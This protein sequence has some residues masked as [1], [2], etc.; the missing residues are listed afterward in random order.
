MFVRPCG[1]TRSR[2]YRCV[3]RDEDQ[4]STVIA[5]LRSPT[6]P[7]YAHPDGI[8]RHAK[9]L[10]SLGIG[11]PLG[12]GSGEVCAGDHRSNVRPHVRWQHG[13]GSS[14]ALA[15]TRRNRAAQ[16]PIMGRGKAGNRGLRAHWTAMDRVIPALARPGKGWGSRDSPEGDTISVDAPPSTSIQY[17]FRLADWAWSIPAGADANA[18]SSKS[19]SFTLFRRG[20]EALGQLDAGSP[21]VRDKSHFHAR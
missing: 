17:M 15:R 21:W 7:V 13:M 8:G 18:N 19:S 14:V 20:S 1:R 12:H 10:G 16:S 5:W 6:E 3:I 4:R 9:P 11:Q 2:F